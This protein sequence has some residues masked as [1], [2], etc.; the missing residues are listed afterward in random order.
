MKVKTELKV[1]VINIKLIISYSKKILLIELLKEKKKD[2][3]YIQ[4]TFF[5]KNDLKNAEI[6]LEKEE[7]IDYKNL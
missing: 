1:L 4:E 6:D 3:A 2:I 5:M 7:V